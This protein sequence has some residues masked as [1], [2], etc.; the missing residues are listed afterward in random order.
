MTQ[1]LLKPKSVARRLGVTP[2]RVRQLDDDLKPLRTECGARFYLAD[3]V[4]RYAARRDARR[5]R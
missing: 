2:A 3:D 1:L 5:A 4:E